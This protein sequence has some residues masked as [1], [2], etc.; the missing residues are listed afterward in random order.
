[1]SEQQHAVLISERLEAVTRLAARRSIGSIER[2][3]TQEF[4]P[5]RHDDAANAAVMGLPWAL[6][7]A[8]SLST[9]WDDRLRIP[10]PALRL[11]RV[12]PCSATAPFRVG[13]RPI[14][15]IARDGCSGGTEPSVE[16]LPGKVSQ[17]GLD[18]LA[19]LNKTNELFAALQG[20]RVRP[21]RC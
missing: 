6:A 11:L 8:L 21:R 2:R 17:L 16:L 3:L 14:E 1:M 15:R 4:R 18:N 10:R 13:S 9:H 20:W 19:D 5:H 7:V 12:Q